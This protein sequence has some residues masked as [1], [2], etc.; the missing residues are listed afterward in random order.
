MFDKSFNKL[1]KYNEKEVLDSDGIVVL[2]PY[3]I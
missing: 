1:I 3:V 2:R